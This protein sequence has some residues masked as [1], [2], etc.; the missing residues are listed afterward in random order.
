MRT[1]LI[2]N[3][4]E[5][6][7]RVIRC[8]H[9]LGIE[10]V[11]VFS[12]ADAGLPFVREADRAVRIGPPP[13]DQC[14]LDMERILDAARRTGAEGVHPGYGFLAENAVF[15][16]AVIAAGLT[17][18]GPPPAALRAMGDKS[19]ARRLAHEQGVSPVPGYDG[20]DQNDATFAREA[21]RIGF[22][23]LVKAA[24]GGGGR[25]M[26]RVEQA[27]EL[28][29]A[30]ASARREAKS[31]FGDDTLL[32]ER[33]LE[34][35]RHIEVQVMGDTHGNVLHLGE[36]ECSI[37][38]RH[39][40]I[41]EESPS[42]AVDDALR[43][44]LGQAAVKVARAA[45]YT[46]AGTVEF[47]LDPEGHFY[48]LEMNTRLQ[49]EH[50]VTE[51]VTGLDLVALQIR[52]AEGR[53]LPLTQDEVPLQGH[54][55]EARLYAE[56]PNRDYLP[57][58]GLLVRFDL[59]SGDGIRIDSGYRSGDTVGVYYD[60]MLAKV[61]AWGVDRDEASRRLLRAVDRSW[62]PG[63]VTN[64]PLLRQV[65]AHPAWTSGELDTGFLPRHGLP[66]LPPLNLDRGAVAA[67]TFGWWH[68]M[69]R[70]TWPGEV[71]P[72]WRMGGPA[73]AE[74]R[75][76]CGNT[77]VLVAWRTLGPDQLEVTVT[78]DEEAPATH[79]IRVLG[80]D[81]DALTV[82]LDG[83]VS[84]WRSALRKAHPGDPTQ[85]EDDDVV[86]THFGDGESMMALAP[87]F[88]PPL[89]A[90]APAGSCIA[91]TP[92]TVTALHVAEGQEVRK[93]ERLATIE[94]MKMEHVLEAPEDGT[95]IAVL[96]EVGQAVDQ[97][98]VL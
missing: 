8:C 68:R 11:A 18:I 32:L 10:A 71:L 78:V 29:D 40:K 50:P 47:L 38:R 46:N 33:Y 22:P 31:A 23:V 92:G 73:V 16:E 83:V 79:Q 88:P 63:V 49:V 1:I 57:S 90:D 4:G 26:R 69:Q 94:A 30:L 51:L 64:L 7:R 91:P 3:R 43:A 39:Q 65:L 13:A 75:W 85:I 62:V 42:P 81:G 12:D 96:V 9:S 14:Y 58:T 59:P 20:A 87:R 21:E 44:A 66:A 17:W 70:A 72:G 19:A 76:R 82:E 61:L 2:A 86:Y 53:P 93:G 5:I 34:R 95:V 84:T 98:A 6:A 52:V 56:D 89:A 80:S 45:G 37:Q 55:I 77:E 60:S 36:R 25:G 41:F 35:P 54:A 48:F 67:T 15:A 97:G 24:A 74:D 28:P 27:A